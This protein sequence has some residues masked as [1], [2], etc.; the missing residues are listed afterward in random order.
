MAKCG[1]TCKKG[2]PV[3]GI[4]AGQIKKI[5]TLQRAVGV[6]DGVY[7][8]LVKEYS[9]GRTR[10]CTGMDYYEA[11]RLIDHLENIAMKMNIKW[12][13]V[14]SK[15][16]KYKCLADRD[17]EMATPAQLRMIEAMW[18]ERSYAKDID[19]EKMLRRFLERFGVSDI[20]FLTKED[21]RRVK[22][23]L[24]NM[25]ILTA[26]SAARR[27]KQYALRVQA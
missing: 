19:K 9:G 13:K 20:L 16:D 4:T 27:R 23:A 25:P 15:C 18:K 11:G 1:S 12:Q 6:D 2:T 17:D 21:V 14:N 26:V 5:K 8:L 7:E 24:D 3:T 22:R 10:S